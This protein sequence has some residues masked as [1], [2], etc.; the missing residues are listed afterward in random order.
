MKFLFILLKKWQK[1]PCKLEETDK[2]SIY[3]KTLR[4][5]FDG[6][7]LLIFQFNFDMNL[8]KNSAHWKYIKD[9]TFF[10]LQVK[11]KTKTTPSKQVS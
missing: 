6:I 11:T 8:S 3:A 4:I 9:N 1:L 5:R 10:A 7:S 2:L